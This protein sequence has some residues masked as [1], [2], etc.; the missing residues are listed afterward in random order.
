M[1]FP[2]FFDA[3]DRIVDKRS[4]TRFTLEMND[5]YG[6][7]FQVFF[8]YAEMQDLNIGFAAKLQQ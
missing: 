3:A 1:M 2:G 7:V 5:I 4:W 6:V 8:G